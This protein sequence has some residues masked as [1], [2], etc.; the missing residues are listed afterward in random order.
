VSEA[1]TRR[2]W[3]IDGH[4]MIF[5]LPQLAALQE[6]GERALARTRLEDFVAGFASR[7]RDPL[8]IV[9]DGD[10]DSPAGKRSA[11]PVRVLF[12]RPAEEAD[13]RI[14]AMAEQAVREGRAVAVVSNDRRSLA[15]KLPRA[16]AVSSVEE[17]VE[18]WIEPPPHA[19]RK[20]E[21]H[22]PPED[23]RDVAARLIEHHEQSEAAS[24]RE[25]RRLGQRALRQ[26]VARFGPRKAAPAASGAAEDGTGTTGSEH[27]GRA[28]A[29][30][31]RGGRGA[32]ATRSKQT[33][34]REPSAPT[35]VADAAR[36]ARR[37]RG[38]RRQRRRLE[39][40]AR[41]RKGKER[42]RTDAS[43]AK[44]GRKSK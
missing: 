7:L 35:P 41:R 28:K 40:I 13:D 43:R 8:I 24:R 37:R 30:A 1:W 21:K 2:L 14:I 15:S 32:P 26:W 36:E 44:G 38:L 6:A 33:D 31:W 34:A 18:R 25:A 27:R 42:G 17:F 3:I 39:E 11:S 5:S 10:R 22:L 16:V 20:R 19:P 29:P 12:S 9:Y 23:A 4:N